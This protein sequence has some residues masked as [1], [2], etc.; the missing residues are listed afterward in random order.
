MAESTHVSR[1]PNGGNS[2][3]T[4]L[5]SH[6]CLL[7]FEGAATHVAAPAASV[8]R[9][10]ARSADVD[11]FVAPQ[12]VAAAQETAL[13]RLTSHT[14]GAQGSFM[15]STLAMFAQP[16]G[17][18]TSRG[19][20]FK[21]R[22]FSGLRCTQGAAGWFVPPLAC[23]HTASAVATARRWIGRLRQHFWPAISTGL[24][25]GNGNNFPVVSF[26][27]CGKAQLK[28]FPTVTATATA[29]RFCPASFELA[30]T[31]PWHVDTQP[32]LSQTNFCA[33]R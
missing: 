25:R 33:A 31:I 24:R 4:A 15:V 32:L 11:T 23:G 9:V 8:G 6:H 10:L 27:F 16:G 17:I 1:Q 7:L 20:T 2:T 19:R 12:E 22:E 13:A 18:G 28:V 3:R 21:G 14:D 29:S 26:T 5:A 30:G